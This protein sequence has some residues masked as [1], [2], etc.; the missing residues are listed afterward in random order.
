[1][2]R[3]RLGAMALFSEKYG[4]VVR[5]VEVGDGSFSRE[6]CGGTHVRLTSELGLFRILGETSSAANVRRIE[7]ITG[8]EAVDLL[9]S[10]D[11]ELQRAASALRV[12]PDQV[13]DAVGQ[14][15]GRVRELE[16]AA[17]SSQG[18]NGAVDIDELAAGAV[19]SAGANVL[20]AAVSVA[21]GQALLEVVDRLKGRLGDAAIVLGSAGQGR[22]DL[23]ASVAPALGGPWRAGRRDRQGRRPARGRRRRWPRHPGPGRRPGPRAIAGRSGGGARGDRGGA[24]AS[25]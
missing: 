7:A 17:R 14:L 21:D 12:P 22:V 11:R 9:R 15:S 25:S 16:R 18:A 1:M 19:Q 5:M 8:P 3:K 4:D 20:A 10:H 13:A 6:L 23:V 2:R 24:V